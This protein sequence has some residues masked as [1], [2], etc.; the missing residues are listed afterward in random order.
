MRNVGR[1]AALVCIVVGPTIAGEIPA[2]Q[3]RS[4]STFMSEAARTMQADDTSNPGMLGVLEGS[5]LW[6]APAGDAGKSCASCHGEATESMRGVAAR[7]PAYDERSARPIDL[8]GKDKC[9]SGEPS[10]RLGAEA[11]RR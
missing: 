11:R 1:C 10:A 2:G 8:A 5:R 9:M 3:R 7:Y 4:G 6:D